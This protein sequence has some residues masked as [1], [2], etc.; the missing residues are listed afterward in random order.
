MAS[1]AS[2]RKSHLTLSNAAV[3]STCTAAPPLPS[4]SS[5]LAT[6][7][8]KS[9]LSHILLPS[10]RYAICVFPTTAVVAGASFS[11]TAFIR[12]RYAVLVTATGL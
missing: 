5:S 2:C 4:A 11:C 3:L 6:S 9:V 8:N 7:A 1:M 12:T 10:V